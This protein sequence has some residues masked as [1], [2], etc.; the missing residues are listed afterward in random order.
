MISEI[1]NPFEDEAC[2]FCGRDN[3]SGLKL[4]FYHDDEAGEV[5]TDY[6]PESQFC[7]QGEVFHGGMQ[8]GLLD[9]VMWWAGYVETGIKEA[10]T[11]TASFRFLRPVYIGK[12]IRAACRVKSF[13]GKTIKLK[14]RIINPQGQVCTTISGQYR[15]L[16]K[17]KYTAVVAGASD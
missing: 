16:D 7:G 12:P 1:P 9:E 6:T 4:I 10:V 17:D 5:F 3:E 13:D 11:V 14:G 15:I 8:M 2:F